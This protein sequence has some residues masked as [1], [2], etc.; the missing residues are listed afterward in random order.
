MRIFCGVDTSKNWLDAFVGKVHRRFP[1]TEQGCLELAELCREQAVELVVMEASG[2]LEQPAFLT[3]W[4]LGQPCALANAFSVRR[5][6][7]SMGILEKT[8][9]IDAEMIARFAEAKRM[10]PTPPPSAEQQ[11]LNALATRLRQVTQSLADEKRRLFSTH[12]EMARQSIKETIRF[13]TSQAKALA[14]Q[15]AAMVKADPLWSALEQTIRS[16]KGAADRTVAYLLADLPELGTL[17]NRAIAKLAGLA[18]LPDDSGKRQGR[19]S[20]RGG[21]AHIRSLLFLIADVARKYDPSLAQFRQRLLANGL[22]KMQVR[23]ALAR[24]LLVRLNAKVRDARAAFAM[25]A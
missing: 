24:K 7:E 23:V 3:L 2:G 20:I 21:R 9:R 6:A 19:R 14:D 12:D 22:A 10:V 5:F 4:K 8:D 25:A 13:F 11:R 15:I 1:N 18:P 17:S 16:V